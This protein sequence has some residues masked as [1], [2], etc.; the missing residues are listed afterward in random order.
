MVLSTYC[1]TINEEEKRRKQ[2]ITKLREFVTSIQIFRYNKD[3][4]RC[5]PLWNAIKILYLMVAKSVQPL[6]GVLV[7]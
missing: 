3:F 1:C 5:K 6:W 4:V 7:K 2:E